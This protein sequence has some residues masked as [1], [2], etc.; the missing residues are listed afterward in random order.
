MSQDFELTHR[1][2][3]RDDVVYKLPRNQSK[4][5]HKA[6]QDLISQLFPLQVSAGSIVRFDLKIRI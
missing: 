5:L 4:T 6:G 1:E 3:M 2:Y